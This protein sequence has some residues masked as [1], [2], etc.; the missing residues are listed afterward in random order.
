MNPKRI[1]VP[2]KNFRMK[3][4]K[5]EIRKLIKDIEY[6]Q[7]TKPKKCPV[8]LADSFIPNLTCFDYSE[9]ELVEV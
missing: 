6:G 8:S 7:L 3:I 2:F 4:Q 9:K 5:C 1:P